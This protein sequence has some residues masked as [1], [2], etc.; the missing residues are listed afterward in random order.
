MTLRKLRNKLLFLTQTA[1]PKK[2]LNLIVKEIELALNRDRLACLPNALTID[3]GNV[4]NLRCPL[5]PTGRG[6]KSAGR[7]L[8]KIE[9]YKKVIDELAP[10]LTNL[11]LHNWGEPLL[12]NGLVDMIRYAKER[13]VPVSISTNLTLLKPDQAEGL[14]GTFIEKIFIS[15][16]GAS[17]ETYGKYRVG[18]DFDDVVDNIRMLVRAKKKIGNR[19]TRLK[20][21]FHVFR[22]N[23]HEIGSIKDLAGRLGV[24]LLIDRMRPDMGKE[25]FEKARDAIRRDKEWMPENKEYSPF[26]LEKEEKLKATSCRELWGKS[27]V[28]WDGSVFPCCAVYG[29]RYSF[30]NALSEGFASVWN[31]KKY[32]AARKE[33][34]GKIKASNTVC[35]ICKQNDFLHL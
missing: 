19:Y 29:D 1:A 16:D 27:V 17:R 33:I 7:G 20:L 9:D 31:G 4:C 32:V 8:M 24:E 30:G 12:H 15:C 18:G 22:H 2:I 14:M 10:C 34:L 5:C 3:I 25:I 26:D 23:E 35:H 13:S 21:L 6:D 11:Q 28:N